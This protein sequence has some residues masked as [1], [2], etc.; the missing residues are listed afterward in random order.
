MAMRANIFITRVVSN[1]KEVAQWQPRRRQR[2]S[3]QP[4]RKQRRRRS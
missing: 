3:L 4:R 1:A 2:R